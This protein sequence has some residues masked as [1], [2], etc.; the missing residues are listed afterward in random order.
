M[1]DKNYSFEEEI[2]DA[3]QGFPMF[4]RRIENMTFKKKVIEYVFISKDQ[5]SQQ[6]QDIIYNSFSYLEK[7]KFN[8][9][10]F[11]IIRTIQETYNLIVHQVR[12]MYNTREQVEANLREIFVHECNIK[13]LND[14][15]KE[16]EKSLQERE[17]NDKN[18]SLIV[19]MLKTYESP[20]SVLKVYIDKDSGLL[21]FDSSGFDQR[22]ISDIQ[23][24]VCCMQ[25][26]KALFISFRDFVEEHKSKDLYPPYMKDI[27]IEVKCFDVINEIFSSRKANIIRKKSKKTRSEYESSL[28][29]EIEAN[30]GK[31]YSFP[32]YETILPDECHINDCNK[33]Y[34]RIN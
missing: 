28:L 27:E 12:L 1:T 17:G 21:V 6:K 5:F 20:V 3:E 4:F 13:W 33:L 14:I 34:G 10:Y 18:L 32:D 9:K 16:A 7:E 15:I 19:K 24:I 31:G 30:E 2:K 8:E 23:T 22:I 11:G 25:V 26:V 29:K